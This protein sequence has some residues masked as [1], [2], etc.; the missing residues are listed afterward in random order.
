MSLFTNPLLPYRQD[1]LSCGAT[2]I[3]KEVSSVPIV[4]IDVWVS[5]GAA[6]EPE[7]YLGLS[8]FYEHMFFKGTKNLGVGEMDRAIKGLGGYN[9]AATAW[10]Y[11]HYYVVVPSSGG[12]RAMEVLID[13]L[14]FP[15]FDPH[16]IESERQVIY[17]EIKRHEDTPWS[18]FCEKFDETAYARCPYSRN[19]LGTF[20]SLAGIDREVF[21][22]FL[23][24][25]YT[26]ENI[27]VVT[28]GDMDRNEVRDRLEHLLEGM[29]PSNCGVTNG[30]FEMIDSPQTFDLH[31][32]VNQSYLLLGYPTPR[33]AGT[34]DEAILDLASILLGEGR[35]SRLYTLLK[36]ELGLVSS[37][38]A[39]CWSQVR[40]GLFVTEAA[41]DEKNLP[42][43][44][45]RTLDELHRLSSTPPDEKELERGKKIAL[46]NYAFSNETVSSISH[47]YGSSRILGDIESV[48]RYPDM[49][50]SITS[51]E[52]SSTLSRYVR[53][54][55]L[56]VGHLLPNEREESELVTETPFPEDQ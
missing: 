23:R 34:R 49:I 5:V 9:N 53:D 3:S 44:E 29:S 18:R 35:S 7:E 28:V 10:D 46:A 6:E 12:Q 51:E 41:T 31:M 47:T 45:K 56:C 33:I 2:F 26:P 25:K 17:E 50:Q 52:L 54:N 13:A 16:E 21:L 19:I 43:V 14:R 40:A 37:I 48:V 38:S 4:A 36:E 42:E 27:T 22:E 1:I 15:L 30:A 11:T 55:L 8:H 20:E 39:S 24:T 32:P